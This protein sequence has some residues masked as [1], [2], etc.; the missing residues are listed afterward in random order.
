MY[1]RGGSRQSFG[2]GGFSPPG[3][4]PRDVIVLV[5]VV[6]VTFAMQ[7]FAGASTLVAALRLTPLVFSGWLWQLATYPFIGAGGPSLWFL[8]ELLILFWFARDTFWALGRN[9]FWRTLVTATLVAGGVATVVALVAGG[10]STFILMQG[11]YMLLTVVIAAF[12]T[13]FGDATILL[14]FILPIRARWFLGIEILFAFMGYLGTRDLAGFLGLCT[15]VGATYLLLSPGGPGRE[16]RRWRK[17][18]EQRLLELRLKRMR[19][20]RGFRVVDG[21]GGRKDGDGRD[22]WVH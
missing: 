6:F 12:A 18:A 2:F 10:A 19:R 15:A 17:R 3:P 20:S 11:Q 1:A 13:L 4:P 21:E 9:R 8:L 22:R 7:F 5:A 14:F 16:L